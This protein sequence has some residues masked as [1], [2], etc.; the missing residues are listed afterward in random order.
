MAEA[1]TRSK[2]LVHLDGNPVSR[3]MHKHMPFLFR[4]DSVFYFG[5]FV[6]LLGFAWTAY[7]LFTDSFTQLLNWDYTWQYV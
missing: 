1:P 3:W 5:L 4:W 2:P 7:S 6:F